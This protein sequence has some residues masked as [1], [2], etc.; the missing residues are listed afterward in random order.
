[1]PATA[2]WLVFAVQI[3]F[4]A[5]GLYFAP[6]LLAVYRARGSLEKAQKLLND[7]RRLLRRRNRRFRFTAVL[8]SILFAG[9]LAEI[10]FRVFQIRLT[11]ARSPTIDAGEVDNRL[12]ALGLR[13]AWD[14]LPMDDP[15]LRI[16]FLGDSLTYGEAVEPSESF[17]RLIEGLLRD[18]T[19]QGVAT[20]NMGVPGTGPAE[21][22]Q[23]FERVGPAVQ[24]HLVVHVVYPNDWGVASKAILGRIYRIRDDQ[25][26]MGTNSYLLS[27]VERQIRYKLAWK[28]TID[29]FR[30]GADQ[31]QRERSWQR[32]EGRLQL[33]CNAVEQSG[34]TYALVMFPWLAR[35]DD[36]LLIEEHDRLQAWATERQIPF[37]DL[38]ETFRGQNAEWFRISLANEHPNPEGHRMAAER[39]AGFLRDDVFP[40]MKKAGRLKE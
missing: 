13:E 28:S 7:P 9:V 34:A 38:L 8:L 31:T 19:P 26:F 33:T 29:Y 4:F 10:F 30:G 15:R 16:A 12:N 40:Q 32:F 11:P 20:I 21:Q 18:A 36:Y 39:I 27:Y 17:S 5:L 2:A 24:P 22:L 23:L 25:L 1:M 3:V 37:L 14:S 35:L 6:A